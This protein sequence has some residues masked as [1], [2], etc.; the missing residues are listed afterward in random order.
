MGFV[1][2]NDGFILPVSLFSVV[3][4]VC[5][6]CGRRNVAVSTIYGISLSR[7]LADFYDGAV[8]FKV[9]C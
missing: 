3:I 5:P 6:S 1:S 7:F 9:W 8:G 2:Q 4:S